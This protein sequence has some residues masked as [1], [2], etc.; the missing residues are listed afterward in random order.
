MADTIDIVVPDIGDFEGI[1]VIEVL[2]KPGDAVKKN[3]SLITL[4]SDKASMEVPSSS[5]GTV[6]EMLVK[7]GDKVSKGTVIAKLS[8]STA[9]PAAAHAP[10]A[11]PTATPAPVIPSVGSEATAVEG[12]SPSTTI[13][14]L[15]V[16]DIGDFSDIPVIEVLIKA[17]D[18]IAKEQS[19]VTLESD[20]A[21]MEVPA[22]ASGT[23]QDVRV[24]VGDKVAKGTVLATVAV[25]AA[26]ASSI[27]AAP[28]AAAVAPAPAAAVAPAAVIPSVASN[29]SAVE[30]Q[31]AI[32]ASPSIRRFARELGVD[33]RGVRGTGPNAR[34][35]R[36]DV[37]G[38]VKAAL[39]GG[40]SAG[41]G[42]LPGLPP[43]PKVDFAQFGP[44]ERTPLSRIKKLSG[45]NLHRNWVQIPHITNY[46]EADITDLEAFRN[47][48]NAE[49][50]K[51]GGPKLTM[52]A[53][54][55][56]AGVR[57]L[58]K[59]PDFNASLD[60]DALIHKG[61][62]NIGFAADTPNGLVVPVVKNADK[63]GVLEIAAESAA[64]AA[65]A[66]DGKL[67]LA[68]MQG[69]TFTIS[70]IG[71]IG[72]TAFTQIVNAPEVAIMGATRS[73]MKPVWDGTQFVPRLMLPVSVSYDHRVIDGA[74]AAR[75]LVYLTGLLKDFRRT[76]L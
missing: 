22:T 73:A 10:A 13:V 14:E 7:V 30:G 72:G 45:P 9:S 57:A 23:V 4:E 37:Q 20:K 34:V 18:E 71:G 68:D 17:G 26:S 62:Y 38:F 74:S 63:K 56:K 33:L 69:G 19:V 64:L 67:G 44:I 16:P 75:F 59:F 3:D 48:I 46:D 61:Y 29:A 12:Q 76:A 1:P 35:T 47:E 24:K 43:W 28:A 11:A 65:K 21:S 32:H 2:A 36:E 42:A 40:A 53:F 8:G 31:T 51:T 5:D 15:T 49:Q 55:V 60:G 50:A 27:A 25:K 70:S 54:L 41:G 66:R 52:L 6:V 58:E 39:A